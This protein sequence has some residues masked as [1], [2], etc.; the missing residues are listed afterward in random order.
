MLLVILIFPDFNST[1]ASSSGVLDGAESNVYRVG[2]L[3]FESAEV[4][5]DFISG[6]IIENLCYKM[7]TG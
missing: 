3:I 2:V 6:N 1:A 5:E 7:I 4:F